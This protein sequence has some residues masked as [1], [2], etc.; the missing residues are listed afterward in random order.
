MFR[1]YGP[2]SFAVCLEG[3]QDLYRVGCWDISLFPYL[4]FN[5]GPIYIFQRLKHLPSV[6]FMHVHVCFVW[7]K[8]AV[9]S[10]F[11]FGFLCFC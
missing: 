11:C 9:D 8:V 5:M 6:W 3:F 7:T 10:R 2:G 1:V 4:V